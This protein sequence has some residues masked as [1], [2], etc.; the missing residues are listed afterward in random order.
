MDLDGGSDEA[1]EEA[2]GRGEP[3]RLVGLMARRRE[4]LRNSTPYF[5]RPHIHPERRL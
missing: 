2:L 4:R 3:D 1:V 5:H